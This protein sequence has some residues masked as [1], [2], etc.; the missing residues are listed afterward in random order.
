MGRLGIFLTRRQ[1]ATIRRLVVVAELANSTEMLDLRRIVD[2]EYKFAERSR[3]LGWADYE[4]TD[5]QE[6]EYHEAI[7]RDQVNLRLERAIQEVDCPYC[8]ANAGS[9]CTNKSGTTK[10]HY[11][12]VQYMESPDG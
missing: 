4:W 2:S 9:P 10:T 6:R 3:E 12:R 11:Q 5:Q 8:N 7:A 1:I